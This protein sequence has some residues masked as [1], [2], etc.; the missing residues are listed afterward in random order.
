MAAVATK[1]RISQNG[2][3]VKSAVKRIAVTIRGL[4]P[5]IIFQGKGVMAADE[6]ESSKKKK[7]RPPEEE[8]R[9]R[10]HWT[11][12]NGKKE[13]CIPWVMLYQSICTAAGSFKFRGQKTMATVVAA[14]ISCETDRI[15]LGTEK[16]ETLEEY[17]RIPPRTGVMVNIGRPKLPKW[18]ASFAM[19]VDD[20]MYSADGLKDII[21]HAGKLVGIGAWRPQLKGPYGRFE[22]AEFEI[23]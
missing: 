22:V 14:T 18:E 12:V 23:Q 21:A 3:S 8:A 15:P 6:G 20:E 9:L 17:V 4:P 7:H 13:L 10:A 5:G 19:V 1:N 11:T 2:S 16:F